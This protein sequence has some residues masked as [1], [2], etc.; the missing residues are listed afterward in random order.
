LTEDRVGVIGAGPAG[1]AAAYSLT[2]MGVPADVF[3]A[4]PAV[5]GMARTLELWDQKVDLGPHRFFSTDARVNRFWLEVVGNDYRM[6]N[7][8]TRIYYDGKMFAYPLRL[9]NS[10]TRLGPAEAA[11][12]LLSYLRASLRPNRQ[13]PARSFEEWVCRRFGRRLYELF[14]RSY[15]EK[16]WGIPCSQLDADFAAQRI[17]KLSIYQALKNALLNGRG[18]RHPTLIDCFAY[19]LGGTGSVYATM[20]DRIGRQGGTVQLNSPVRLI[21]PREDGMLELELGSGER[22]EYARLLSSMPLTHLIRALPDVPEDVTEAASGM[23]FRNTILVYLRVE[24]QDLFPDQWIY[25]HSGELEVGRITNFRNWVP[26]LYGDSPDTILSLELWCNPDDETWRQPDSRHIE[27]ARQD[28]GKLGLT[29]G[30]RISDGHVIRVPNCYPVYD[31]GYRDRLAVIRG[32]LQKIPGL[33]TIGRGG[34]FRYNNQDHSLLMGI[35]AAENIAC[36]GEHD[37]WSLNTDDT[38]Q[39][40]AFI[41]ETGLVVQASG[42]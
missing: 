41:H 33:Q 12:C 30:T 8:L 18:N 22:R 3:E 1:L 2:S 31:L 27:R 11:R 24:G 37:L 36:G 7:R 16:L 39:E 6:V 19:P 15:S 28:L 32:Y 42:P 25:V 13:D 26:E 29:E 21:N 17:R 35:L 10:L 23:R 4:G 40:A 20:A 9:A 14:F 38:Y 34:A 5:G